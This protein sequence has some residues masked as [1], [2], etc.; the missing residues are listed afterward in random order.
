M[1]QL[2]LGVEK[3]EEKHIYHLEEAAIGGDPA[4]RRNLGNDEL[5]NGRFDRA[6][7]HWIIAAYLGD[8]NTLKGLKELYADG[9]ASKDDYATALRACQAAVDATKSAERD[10]AEAYYALD[11]AQKGNVSK[12]DYNA[13]LRK[14]YAAMEATK[15][16]REGGSSNN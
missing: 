11:A 1:Y 6:R 8:Q 16:C 13:A 12:E 3:D 9:Y 7:K 5:R 10:E 14:Y 2:G 4:A 15:R